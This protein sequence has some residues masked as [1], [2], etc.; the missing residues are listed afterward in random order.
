MLVKLILVSGLF[1]IV[2]IYVHL[3]KMKCSID[4]WIERALSE[5]RCDE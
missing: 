4:V 2:G 3:S 5:W 1:G